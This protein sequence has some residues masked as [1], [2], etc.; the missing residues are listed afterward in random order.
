MG[1]IMGFLVF[2]KISNLKDNKIYEVTKKIFSQK[3]VF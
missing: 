2:D 1:Y 3:K